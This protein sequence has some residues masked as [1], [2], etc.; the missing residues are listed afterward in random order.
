MSHKWK[1]QRNGRQKP[2]LVESSHGGLC[3]LE[4]TADN[5]RAACSKPGSRPKCLMTQAGSLPPLPLGTSVYSLDWAGGAHSWHWAH[6]SQHVF[7]ESRSKCCILGLW[8]ANIRREPSLEKRNT[9]YRKKEEEEERNDTLIASRRVW[10]WIDLHFQS[11]R[12]DEHLPERWSF[13]KRRHLK[14]F[15]WSFF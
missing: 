9:L 14:A 4:S 7:T 12:D 13:P 6:I 5:A 15:E 3:Q 10:D 11:L 1:I 2:A 8:T